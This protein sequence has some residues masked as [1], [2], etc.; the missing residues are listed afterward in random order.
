MIRQRTILRNISFEGLALHSG[1]LV[2]VE[3]C[4]AEVDQGVVFRRTDLDP[5]KDIRVTNCKVT[6]TQL[7]STI[8]E[9]NIKMSTVE[10]MVA[11]LAG[12]GIDNILVKVCGPELPILDGSSAI[13]VHLLKTAGCREQRGRKKFIEVLKPIK[14]EEGDK[15]AM[16]EPYFGFKLNFTVDFDHP[17]VNEKNSMVDIDFKNSSFVEDISRARTFG[18]MSDIGNLLNKNLVVGGGLDNAIVLNDRKIVNKGGLRTD[19]EL[20]M[21]KA[22]D[23]IGD[24]YLKGFPLLGSYRAY[25]SGHALNNK[26]IRELTTDSD[27]WRYRTFSSLKDAPLAWSRQWSWV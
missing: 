7:A 6:G 14:V 3:I 25:K 21:H 15:W 20:A 23:A 13:F 27:S 2:S 8:S 10:H 17:A 24:L 5:P 4:P 1:K 18:F 11:A 22:L 26:L 9:N 12:L 19:N 16:L